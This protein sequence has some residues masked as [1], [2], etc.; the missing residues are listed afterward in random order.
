VE[1]IPNYDRIKT[2]L[3]DEPEIVQCA[4]C[5]DDTYKIDSLETVKGYLCES[6]MEL[7]E[8]ENGEI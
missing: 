5:G 7:E 1:R 8:E 6:C 2:A 3:P 4:R